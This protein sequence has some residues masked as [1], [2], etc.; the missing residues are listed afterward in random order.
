MPAVELCCNKIVQFLT[1]SAS[2]LLDSIV[3][4]VAASAAVVI[5]VIVVGVVC[6]NS[7]AGNI[8]SIKCVC[9]LFI[10]SLMLQLIHMCCLFAVFRRALL[11]ICCDQRLLS[12]YFICIT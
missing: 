7:Y 9:G 8:P 11:D 5:V 2:Y 10:L 12:H 6:Y 4:V 1:G 3:V